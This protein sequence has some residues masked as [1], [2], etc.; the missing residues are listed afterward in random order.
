MA[1]F[2][3]KLASLLSESGTWD[4][5]ILYLAH[6]WC[7]IFAS[8]VQ[9]QKHTYIT[10]RITVQ[11][12]NPS[13]SSTSKPIKWKNRM[14]F[15]PHHLKLI[16]IYSLLF[17]CRKLGYITIT[18]L[19]CQQCEQ[20]WPQTKNGIKWN[21]GQQTQGKVSMKEENFQKQITWTKV[22]RDPKAKWKETH[23]MLGTVGQEVQQQMH[24]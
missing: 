23:V 1:Q 11:H 13:V 5:G 16:S 18:S 14:W 15:V 20:S 21:Y 19:I 2:Q 12:Y 17:L 4:I 8:N 22:G 9:K 7:K 3:S 10:H 6:N 24:N